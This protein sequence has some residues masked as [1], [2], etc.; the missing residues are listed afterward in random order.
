MKKKTN[1]QSVAGEARKHRTGPVKSRAQITVRIDSELMRSVYAQLKEDNSRIT[2]AVERGLV[3]WLTE[4]RHQLP[5]WSKQVRFVL[6][7]CT[8]EQAEAIRG[9]AIALV[10]NEIEERAPDA[11][12]IFDLCDW[13]VRSRNSIPNA[14]K[15]LEL[16]SRYG[17]SAGEISKLG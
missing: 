2:D 8:T 14:G 9:L 17:R 13:F 16:Y 3:L 4:A 10:E 12:A 6:A 11:Q 7:N 15:C 1:L 5:S